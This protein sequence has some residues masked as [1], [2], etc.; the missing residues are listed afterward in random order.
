MTKNDQ[1]EPIGVLLTNLGSPDDTSVPA[2]RRYLR[3]FLSDPR[4]IDLPR[5]KWLPILYGIVLVTRPRRSADS[6][7]GIWTERGSPL[8]VHAHDQGQAIQ[9][10]LEEQLDQ[11]VHVQVA[12]RYGNPSLA[13]GLQ[14]LFTQGCHKILVLPAYPQYSATTVA[15]TYDKISRV[16]ADWPHTPALRQVTSYHDN[17]DYIQALANSVREHWQAHGRG[18]KLVMSFHGIP[19]RYV[20]QGDPY[21][22]ECRTTARLLAE[23]LGLEADDYQLCYQSRFGREAWLQPYLDETMKAWGQNPN[24]KT[25]DVINPGFSADCLETL[26]EIAVENRE[27]FETAPDKK[28]RYIPAL[29]ER[30]DHIDMFVNMIRRGLAGWL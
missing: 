5:L 28:L 22:R 8:I 17:P 25:I 30:E 6:Y 3:E 29:N 26:E 13:S 7:Q 20:D 12:M 10:R 14:H 4:V 16:L 19:K 21:A 11:P 27:Y 9:T 18:N 15:T 23:T 2:V 24:I 1:Q